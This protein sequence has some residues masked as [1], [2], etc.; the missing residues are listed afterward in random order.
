MSSEAK[1]SLD[2]QYKGLVVRFKLL[3]NGQDILAKLG[4]LPIG[5]S[6]V[7]TRIFGALKNLKP[8]ISS[9]NALVINASL[10]AISSQLQEYH[11]WLRQCNNTI[12]PYGLRQY[13]NENL[14]TRDELLNLVRLQIS[15]HSD[16]P[17]DR[18]KVELLL[19]KLCKDAEEEE[20]ERLLLELFPDPP[21]LTFAAQEMIGQL[22]SLTKQIESLTEFP[23]LVMG[24][25]MA[26]ARRLK[27][28]LGN[29]VWH[30]HVMLAINA[31]NEAFELC[32]TYL[33]NAERRLIIEACRRLLHS[34]INSIGKM[35]ENGVL[36][37]EAAARL[38]EK[39]DDLL[40]QNYQTNIQ[41]L[42][43]IAQI[44]TWLRNAMELLD[45]RGQDETDEEV[46]SPTRIAPPYPAPAPA[47]IAATPLSARPTTERDS[48]LSPIS[49]VLDYADMEAMERQ[50][51]ARIEEIAQVLASR[52]RRSSLQ[53]IQLKR[54][55]MLLGEWEGEAMVSFGNLVDA[56]RRHFFDILRR[57]LA[58]VA[59]LQESAVVFAEGAAQPKSN[60]SS[61]HYSIPAT[62]YFLEQARRAQGELETCSQ[63]ARA[64]GDI[65]MSLNLLAT[66]TKVQDAYNKMV[67]VIKDAG[68]DM[69]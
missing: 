60:R 64:K 52:P 44:G 11:E 48:T 61:H 38:A 23:Q 59:E 5:S 47:Q 62:V 65:E 26:R 63:S 20:T 67:K 40:E 57:S 21:A 4:H 50:I 18:G 30:P 28:D 25:Y 39:A 31:L 10:S 68:L 16:S 34:G 19:S 22:N 3:H 32:F 12:T 2:Q 8:L 42:Q 15:L 35:G 49:T 69:H 1:G 41:R 27:F 29:A 56:M 6:A 45:R 43:Q 46:D 13:C 55:V 51:M 54:T 58:L 24:D 14:L 33:F 9:G 17:D 66:R 36:N 53:V 7:E 37:V